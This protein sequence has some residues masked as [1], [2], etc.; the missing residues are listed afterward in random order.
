MKHL[1]LVR[2]GNYTIRDGGYHLS[3]GGEQEM[4]VLGDIMKRVG[5]GDFYITSSPEDVAIESAR[6]LSEKLDIAQP[7][8]SMELWSGGLGPAESNA[9]GNPERV[10]NYLMQR[11]D[12]ANS[13]IAVS[14]L[15]IAK[16]YPT[17]FLEE[18]FGNTG[19]VPLKKG[20]MVH[21]DLEQMAYN[22]YRG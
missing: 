8:E 20:Q 2:H 11:K 21:F 12:K 4:N 10:H 1:F 19:S 9:H 17:Y 3:T 15:E 22:T 18:F 13:L 14:H 7:E 16:K 5:T 6:V